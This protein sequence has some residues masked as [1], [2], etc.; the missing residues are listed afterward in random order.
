MPQTQRGRRSQSLSEMALHYRKSM[1]Y[2]S[3]CATVAPSS[4]RDRQKLGGWMSEM[5]GRW[6]GVRRRV[7]V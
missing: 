6:A 1:R 7:C 4:V 2:A 5:P 3:S